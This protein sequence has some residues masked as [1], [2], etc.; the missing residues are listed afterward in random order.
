MRTA[1]FGDGSTVAALRRLTS[2]LK[3]DIGRYATESTTGIAQDLGAHLRGDLRPL[4]GL[5][6]DLARLS[7]YRTNVATATLFAGT[8]QTAL[9]KLDTSASDY[10]AALVTAAGSSQPAEIEAVLGE[11]QGRFEAA[12]SALNTR[13]GD[14]SLLAGQGLKGAALASASDILDRLEALVAGATGADDVEDAVSQWF[15]DPSGFATEG[16]LGDAPL[17]PVEVAPGEAVRLEITAADPALRGTLA[18]LAMAALLDRGVL[19]GSD[20][21]RADLGR[22]AGEQLMSCQTERSQLAARLGTVEG[23]LA[24]A[25]T[26]V[27]SEASALEIARAELVAVDTYETATRLQAAQGQLETLYAVTVRLSRLSLVDFL[28]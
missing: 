17:Q 26:R 25:A 9:D 8:I 19:A 21:A 3:A 15:S 10:A 16:Y 20:T 4:A 14:R 2:G 22:R 1:G 28:G 11:G 13:I 6:A 7:A 27:E 5:Q 24:D 12:V 23:A 18:A